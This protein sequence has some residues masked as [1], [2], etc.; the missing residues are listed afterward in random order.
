MI[1][2]T[3]SKRTPSVPRQ[4]ALGK[5]FALAAIRS[6]FFFPAPAAGNRRI[7]TRPDSRIENGMRQLVFSFSL[8][9]RALPFDLYEYFSRQILG[10][11]GD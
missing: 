5:L 9:Q 1:L 11:L 4:D 6:S 7:S 10:A 8:G 3:Q 2:G